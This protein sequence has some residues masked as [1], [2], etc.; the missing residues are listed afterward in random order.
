MGFGEL[1]LY[2]NRHFVVFDQLPRLQIGKSSRIRR[3]CDSKHRQNLRTLLY[4]QGLTV[5]TANDV[6]D[7]KGYPAIIVIRLKQCK[8]KYPRDAIV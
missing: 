7:Q 1:R 8:V 6:R 2:L 5:L 4:P 3:K